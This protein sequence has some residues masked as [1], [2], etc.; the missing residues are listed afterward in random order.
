MDEFE[1]A[2]SDGGLNKR[3]ASNLKEND[4]EVPGLES[5]RQMIRWAY[6][7]DSEEGDV[8]Q[9][10]EFADDFVVAILSS[11][12]EEGFTD[13]EDVREEIEA[14]TKKEK[15]G[16]QFSKEFEEALSGA[17]DIQGV[18]DKMNLPVEN[19]EDV[20]FGN[21]IIQGFGRELELVGQLAGSELNKLSQPVIGNQGV[22]VVVVTSKTE[23]SEP[24]TYAAEQI[25]LQNKYS[26]KVDYDLLEALKEKG[27]ITDNRGKFY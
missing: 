23:T 1:T 10:Y 6:N 21:G 7:A 15:L 2:V 16:E 3:L 8:S 5:P 17:S 9:V 22:F 18:A 26:G 24:A 11:I 4:K 20:A 13:I 25:T 19:K 12:R 27:D 14:A